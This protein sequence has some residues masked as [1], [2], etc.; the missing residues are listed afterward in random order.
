MNCG[1]T[2][3]QECAD[4]WLETNKVCPVCRDGNLVYFL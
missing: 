1:H 3:H 4:K 2:F